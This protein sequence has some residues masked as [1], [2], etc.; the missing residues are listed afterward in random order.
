MLIN[1]LIGQAKDG[2]C[3]LAGVASVTVAEK[4]DGGLPIDKYATWTLKLCD[5]SQQRRNAAFQQTVESFEC[6]MTTAMRSSESVQQF[7]SAD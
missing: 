5:C 2:P 6:L 3:A 1:R 4:F 7:W